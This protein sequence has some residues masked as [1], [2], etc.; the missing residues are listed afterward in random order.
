MSLT[1]EDVW[2]FPICHDLGAS[3][4]SVEVQGD[5]RAP[6]VLSVGGLDL[7]RSVAIGLGEG[8]PEWVSLPLLDLEEGRTVWNDGI[9]DAIQLLNA[10][11]LVVAQDLHIKASHTPGIGHAC[12]SLLSSR[13]F[14]PS[15]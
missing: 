1:L 13:A 15:V 8:L 4:A 3:L 12:G 9:A 7:E 5:V 2:L 6:A 10:N 14:P 11:G